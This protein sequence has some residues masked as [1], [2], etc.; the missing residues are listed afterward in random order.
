MIDPKPRAPVGRCRP[1]LRPAAAFLL[2]SLLLD[3]AV[4]AAPDERTSGKHESASAGKLVS[5]AGSLLRRQATHKDWRSVK[6]DGPVSAT[7]EL[8]A[9]PGGR[10][11]VEV[12]K[13]AARLTLLGNVPEQS[14]F[15]G[16]EAVV[17]LHDNSKVDLEF[18]LER[19][20]VLLSNRKDKGP[21]RVAVRFQ[22]EAYGIDLNE[23]GTEVAV[24]L[25]GRW[26]P[27]VPFA[28][29]PKGK[30]PATA[31]TAPLV[32]VIVLV[33]KGEADLR[34]GTEAYLMRASPTPAMFAWNSVRGPD[35]GPRSLT[36]MPAW[37]EA[38]NNPDKAA[39]AIREAATHV[40]SQLADARD[41]AATLARDVDSDRSARRELAV[42]GLAAVDDLPGLVG[43]LDNDHHA[44]VRRTAIDALQ[45]WIGRAPGQDQDLFNYLVGRRKYTE[46]QAEIVL[47]LLHGFAP[48]EQ[49][50]PDTYESLVA[51]LQSRRLP[52]RTLAAWYLERW[53]PEDAKRIRYDPAA[54]EKERER[55][56]EKWRRLLTE[57]RLPPRPP[58]TGDR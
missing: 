16:R 2:C 17:A 56:V 24:E 40:A 10:G 7:D 25:S 5:G 30:K 18:A 26:V 4:G 37:R 6:A 57:R 11:V 8:M 3:G 36:R 1:I 33:L 35:L 34:T 28:R 22:G 38:E 32:T 45:H 21:V 50:R 44:G 43:A 47:Q 41:A 14:N 12:N 13:G 31:G 20:R 58:T 48:N 27:G 46:G 15:P 9:L 19:G 39:R 53:A 51:Y 29:P 42:Y 55:D 49:D 52:V 23:P 54:P